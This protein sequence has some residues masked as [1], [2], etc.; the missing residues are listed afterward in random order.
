M[1]FIRAIVAAGLIAEEHLELPGVQVDAEAGAQEHEH[2]GISKAHTCR[3][4]RAEDLELGDDG[5]AGTSKRK[6]RLQSAG[7]NARG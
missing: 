4:N 5:G 3:S 6:R 1:N 2:G 7:N